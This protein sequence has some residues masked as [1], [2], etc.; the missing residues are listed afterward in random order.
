M[1]TFRCRVFF[2]ALHNKSTRNVEAI[3]K[4]EKKNKENKDK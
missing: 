3:R 1:E 2:E 4:R